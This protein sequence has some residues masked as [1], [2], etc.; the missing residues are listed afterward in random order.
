MPFCDIHKKNKFA[1]SPV[2][3]LFQNFFRYRCMEA[4]ASQLKIDSHKNLLPAE[5]KIRDAYKRLKKAIKVMLYFCDKF[6]SPMPNDHANV[7]K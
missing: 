2:D 3:N 5:K 4:C 6:P 1:L 7:M